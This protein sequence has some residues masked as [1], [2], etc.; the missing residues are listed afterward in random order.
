MIPFYREGRALSFVLKLAAKRGFAGLVLDGIDLNSAMAAA[1]D[2]RLLAQAADIAKRADERIW[3]E[4]FAR[5][6]CEIDSTPG[7][8][9]RL[10]SILAS[11][12]RCTEAQGLLAGIPDN[13]D[14]ELYRQITAVLHAKTGLAHEAVALFDTLPGRVKRYYPAPVVSATAC[15]MMDQCNIAHTAAFVAKLAEDYPSNLHIRSLNLRCHLFSGDLD[16]VRELTQLPDL[17]LERAAAFDRRAF[18]EA[19]ADSIELAGRANELF[20]FLRDRIRKDPTHWSLYDRATNN[21]R[22][23]ARD[24]EYTELVAT[25]PSGMRMSAEALAVVCRWHVD[26][27]RFEQAQEI[28]DELRPLSAGLFLQSR[29]YFSLYAFA[30]DPGRIDEAFEACVNCGISPL[31]PAVAHSLHTYYYNCSPTTLRNCLAMLELSK[32]SACCH[33]NFWQIYLR[34]LIA[35]GDER[36]AI[37]CYRA[38][39]R[40]LAMGALLRPFGIYFDAMHS[41]HVKAREGWTN[42]IRATRHLCVNAPSSYPR[43]V[44]LKYVETSGAVLLFVTLFN[45]MDYLDWFLAH[46]RALG[47][48]HFFV[49]DNGS[50]D[51]SLERLRDEEDVSV[52][53]NSE[54]F[55]KSGFGVLWVNHLMQ[56]FGVDH[57]CFHVDIDE[58]FV[59]PNCDGTRTLR[60]LLSYCDDR[61]FCLVPAI[62]LDMYPER[63]DGPSD[64]DPFSASCYF[65]L[66]YVTTQTEL[67]PYVMIQGGI[68]QR[69]TGL[70]L[71]MQKSPLVRMAPDVR[72]IECNHSTTHLPVADISGALLHYKFVG[73][74]K[75]RLEQAISRGEH[76]G[77][78]ISYRRLDRAV[79]SSSW[80]KSLLSPH[81]RRYGGTA[82]LLRHGLIQSSGPWEAARLQRTEAMPHVGIARPD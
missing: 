69:L 12:G 34:C 54:S 66:D 43:T 68:R 70:A 25:I 50:N 19:V 2:P 80:S 62:E 33:V 28:L 55:A 59:F 47:V 35:I 39:P 13:A 64:A 82:S 74:M 51:G 20:D 71:S 76:F 10:A 65:D 16:K 15:E 67:P 18:V 7:A 52:F 57:W 21:A 32:A 40:G 14:D 49:I 78:A 60:D 72:Y 38:M 8:R 24:S 56:R 37:E 63:L 45:A 53:S 42:H 6:V 17:T 3:A 26:D 44:D 48:D 29:L 30:R 75:R 77:G 41:L 27:N 23:T 61:G 81:S 73:D 4:R 9:L 11:N 31:E 46:Y 58:G 22:L 36:Q 5:R 1:T 79:G